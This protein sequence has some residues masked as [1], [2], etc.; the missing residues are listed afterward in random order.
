MRKDI[1]NGV[2]L[3]S[4]GRIETAS[5]VAE[6]VRA[7]FCTQEWMDNHADKTSNEVVVTDVGTKELNATRPIP[8]HE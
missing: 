5:D 6:H 2:A 4:S 7:R 1:I 8:D 3:C